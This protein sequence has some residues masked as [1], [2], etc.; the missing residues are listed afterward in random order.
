MALIDLTEGFL[1]KVFTERE[2]L[3]R[4]GVLIRSTLSN[5]KI[6][7]RAQSN[8]VALVLDTLG[9]RPCC[10]GFD[11]HAKEKLRY[12][13]RAL[14]QCECNLAPEVSKPSRTEGLGQLP[15]PLILRF[16]LLQSLVDK[17]AHDS[18]V[19]LV[20][21]SGYGKTAVFRMLVDELRQRSKANIPIDVF[22]YQ[23]ETLEQTDD[24]FERFS[25]FLGIGDNV[26]SSNRSPAARRRLI[27]SRLKQSRRRIV[28]LDS[29]EATESAFQTEF[30]PWLIGE[31]FP[32]SPS[33][34][35]GVLVANVLLMGSQH[36]SKNRRL[37]D[38]PIGVPTDDE[39]RLFLRRLGWT[40]ADQIENVLRCTQKVPQRL[41]F[42]HEQNDAPINNNADFDIDPLF[43]RR[44]ADLDEN[45][46]KILLA[47]SLLRTSFSKELVSTIV[48]V[49]ENVWQDFPHQDLWLQ[50]QLAGGDICLEMHGKLRSFLR[51]KLTTQLEFQQQLHE[52]ASRSLCALANTDSQ[53]PDLTTLRPII[54]AIYH[55]CCSGSHDDA[56][57]LVWK[58]V[59]REQRYYLA[60]ELGAWGETKEM[61]RGFFL[62]G[63]LATDPQI[64]NTFF[65]NL[66]MN[67]LGFCFS[68]TGELDQA[69]QLHQRAIVGTE[70]EGDKL[71]ASFAHR[72]LC[73]MHIFRG[74]VGN[75]IEAAR[76]ASNE[77]NQIDLNLIQ[78]AVQSAVIEARNDCLVYSAWATVLNL[79]F[80]EIEWQNFES[81]AMQQAVY[82]LGGWIYARYLF[83]RCREPVE[84]EEV[85]HRINRL[86]EVNSRFAISRG[87]YLILQGDVALA[88]GQFD[89]ARVWFE[90]AVD[91]S[92]N[93]AFLPILIESQLSYA[94]CVIIMNE[95]RK[96][97]SHLTDALFRAEKAGYSLLEAQGRMVQ[98]MYFHRLGNNEKRDRELQKAEHLIQTFPCPL[99]TKEL[100]GCRDWIRQ[101]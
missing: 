28:I 63:D 46:Q 52:S 62:N 39:A 5:W 89:E 101:N 65:Q 17:L 54:E 29:I 66:V 98:A 100:K 18:C 31:C 85:K 86:M 58:I 23:F 60:I 12:Q 55:S 69:R 25:K 34:E 19:W 77:V 37:A 26:L 33:I 1:E 68:A 6:V 91:R 95:H 35:N 88:R 51:H 93:I 43:E 81:P 4:Q 41:R 14:P 59:S 70:R 45:E 90:S 99:T 92:S 94:R 10:L 32:K 27:P 47:A 78:P 11:E 2:A 49:T 13:L 79:D 7:L 30:L 20:G 3:E 22:R 72:N 87:R 84:F 76:M 40:D 97:R 75:A 53:L 38:V 73:A 71:G 44:F 64:T 61:L 80:D 42:I 15:D 74:E 24:F 8:Q 96:A 21:D 67:A 48:G 16:E 83:L 56:W 9:I 82:G 36:S 57:K 50:S